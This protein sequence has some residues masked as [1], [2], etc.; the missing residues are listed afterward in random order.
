M[1]QIRE[2]RLAARSNK[3]IEPDQELKEVDHDKLIEA[4][5]ELLKPMAINET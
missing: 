4:F 5:D 3:M 2:L 1:K